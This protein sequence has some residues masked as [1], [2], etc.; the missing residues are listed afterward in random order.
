[1]TSSD[2]NLEGNGYMHCHPFCEH[3]NELSRKLNYTTSHWGYMEIVLEP[4]YKSA[5]KVISKIASSSEYN[6]RR[7]Y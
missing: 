7:T 6:Y 2:N 1:M 5:R 3:G 4:T